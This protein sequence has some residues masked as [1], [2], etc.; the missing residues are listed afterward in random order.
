MRSFSS[1]KMAKAMGMDKAGAAAIRRDAKAR[2]AE[3]G[4]IGMTR[5]LGSGA[6]RDGTR[7]WLSQPG[8]ID[9]LRALCR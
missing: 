7:A 8:A 4:I 5:F 1:S 6:A 2:R 3:L 9:Q